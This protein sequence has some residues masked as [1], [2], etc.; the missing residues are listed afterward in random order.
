MANH[1]HELALQP[2]QFAFLVEGLLKLAC[3]FKKLRRTLDDFLFQ[4]AAMLL[5]LL[6]TPGLLNGLR[7]R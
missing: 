2:I 5:H 1:G 4:A 3:L 7:T 6:E